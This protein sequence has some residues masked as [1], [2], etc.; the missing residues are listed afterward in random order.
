[1][2]E[3]H[4]VLAALVASVVIVKLAMRTTLRGA[5]SVDMFRTSNGACQCCRDTGWAPD[6]LN[7]Q[8]VRCACVDQDEAVVASK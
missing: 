7:A 2:D 6:Y 5:S 4:A 8:M 1:M 3:T